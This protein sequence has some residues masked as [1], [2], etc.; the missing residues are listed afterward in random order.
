MTDPRDQLRQRRRPGFTLIEMMMAILLTMLVFAITIPFFRVQTIAVDVGAGRLDAL[1]NAR[2]AQNA[3]DR[4][5]RIAGGVTG[6]PIIVQA[7][8][9]AVTFNVDLVSR[10]ANDANATYY[11]PSADSLSTDSWEPSRQKALPT[12]SKVYPASFYYDATGNQSTA[13]TLSYFLYT[14]ASSGRSDIYT[15]FRRV[16]DRDSTVVTRNIWIPTDT[17]YFFHYY[18]SSS[19]G[20]LTMIPAA[21][22]PIYWDAAS[23]IQDSIA[24]VEMRVAGLYR[25]VRRAAD[26]TRT[27]YH[28]TALLNYGK[29]K[30]A[31]CGDPPSAPGVVTALQ[32][33]DTLLAIQKIRV[34]WTA[35]A[36]E[37]SG[38]A[39]V[40]LYVVQRR[41][42]S[43]TDW[44]PLQNVVAQ[45]LASYSFDDYTFVS[46]TWIYGVFAQDC[47]PSN[48]AVTAAATAVI[49]P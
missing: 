34:S 30:A 38:E 39:D 31:I 12:S 14:D 46:G 42:F 10:L 26:V 49:N 40:G 11:N 7:A 9:F 44:E 18:K 43:S 6:Q 47:S 1:Q 4:E 20:A 8:P 24:V 35:S 13:E 33:L 32:V 19:T 45:G 15:L 28:R 21:S 2:F 3:I 5:L 37:S 41:L 29:L 22:L 23:R 36:S 16:N 27:I 48:S 17:A 25:D